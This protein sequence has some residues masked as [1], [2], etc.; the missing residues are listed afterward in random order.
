MRTDRVKSRYEKSVE[1]ELGI[2]AEGAAVIAAIIA[3]AIKAS[4]TLCTRSRELF[5]KTLSPINP[6]MHR[7]PPSRLLE[8]QRH[9]EW[10]SFVIQSAREHDGL[11]QVL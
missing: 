1:G 3:N 11:R 9:T 2:G 7:M 10:R 6:G 8:S 5:R 4:G